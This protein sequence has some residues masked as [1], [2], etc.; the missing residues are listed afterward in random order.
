[1]RRASTDLIRTRRTHH[2]DGLEKHQV[3]ELLDERGI[4]Q[5]RQGNDRNPNVFRCF[6]DSLLDWDSE[7]RA[8]G[9]HARVID[10]SRSTMR[11]DKSYQ[12]LGGRDVITDPKTPKSIRTVKLPNFLTETISYLSKHPKIGP[13]DRMFP[14]PR[15]SRHAL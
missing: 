6:R 12:R 8:V 5:V 3:N 7:R 1:M 4:P 10:W 9:S 2:E 14:R 11:I 15:A 13:G